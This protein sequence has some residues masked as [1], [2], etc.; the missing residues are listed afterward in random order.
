[1]YRLL[2]RSRP[3]LARA[4]VATQTAVR[5]LLDPRTLRVLAPG[6]LPLLLSPWIWRQ[7]HKEIHS[8]LFRD[9]SLCHYTTWCLRRGLKL[10]RDIAQPDGPFIYFLCA[11]MQIVGGIADA[12]LRK[13]DLALQVLGS[14]AMGAALTPRYA[15]SRPTAL[16]QRAA[17]ALLGVGLWLT[18]YFPLGWQHTLQRDG[19]YGLVGYLGLVLLYSSDAYGERAGR[20]ACFVGGAISSVLLFTR[21]SGIIWVGAGTLTLLFA[22]GAR[23]SALQRMRAGAAGAVAGVVVMLLAV[24]LFGSFRGLWFWYFRFPF[25]FHYH[26]ARKN[27]MTL[28]TEE[29]SSAAL[30]TAA[31]LIGVV[32]GVATRALP[33]RALGIGLAPFLFVVAGCI[34]GKGWPNHVQ[35]GSCAIVPIELV[36]LSELWR[37]NEHRLRW[38]AHHALLA[39]AFLCFVGYRSMQS[40]QEGYYNSLQLPEAIPVDIESAQRIGAYLKKHTLEKDRV[41][42]YGYDLHGLLDAEREP[43]TAYYYNSLLNLDLAFQTYPSA[44]GEEA[45]ASEVDAIHAMQRKISADACPQLV[46][47]PPAAMVFDDLLGG[48]GAVSALCPGLPDVLKTRYKEAPANVPEYH[49]YLRDD[50]TGG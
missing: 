18:W 27:P 2:Q 14:A 32:G 16:L 39:A 17:W 43:A 48:Q 44:A 10:Y 26:W 15:I 37:R 9:A 31:I 20:V 30:T 50:R 12:G 40:L 49:V 45:T 6:L 4:A 46:G 8:P 42:Y 5:A 13:A 22:G 28:L 36:V 3:L 35:Q 11:A 47:A 33:P 23:G 38:A 29:Y 21:Q 24:A 25:V 1:M 41:F 19:Y 7:W 34:A